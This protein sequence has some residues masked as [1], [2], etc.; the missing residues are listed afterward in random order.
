MSEPSRYIL[1]AI[2]TLES[3]FKRLDYKIC[4]IKGDL[5][6]PSLKEN[7]EDNSLYAFRK[8]D[9][10]MYFGKSSYIERKLNE[11]NVEVIHKIRCEFS[12]IA[13]MEWE[14]S[15]KYFFHK[16]F[17][18]YL[19]SDL[20]SFIPSPKTRHKNLLFFKHDPNKIEKISNDVDCIILEGFRY[21]LDITKNG[22]GI[23]FIDPKTMALLNFEEEHTNSN[24]KLFPYCKETSCDE[25]NNCIINKIGL[26]SQNNAEIDESK[27]ICKKYGNKLLVTNGRKEPY[28]IPEDLL[29]YE[30]STRALKKVG[31]YEDFKDKSLI[32]YEKRYKD[33][34]Y[35]IDTI[36]KDNKISVT[37]P[38]SQ[39]LEF[40]SELLKGG[41]I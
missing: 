40:E 35:I 15:L 7:V 21:S 22:E 27:D 24:W 3:D 19:I 34:E 14:K 25:Y 28:L 5:T 11:I 39:L 10:I 6:T 26:V 2:K 1:N 31:A 4:E 37:L 32:M 17:K 23:L 18:K 41:S 16:S 29:F 13:L 12:E 33:T 36:E 30:P 20:E 8:K 9:K 38:D